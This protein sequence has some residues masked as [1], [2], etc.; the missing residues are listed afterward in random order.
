MKTVFLILT[1]TLAA[2]AQGLIDADGARWKHVVVGKL[3]DGKKFDIYVKLP[4]SNGCD[5]PELTVKTRGGPESKVRLDC[6][7]RM[8]RAGD[9]EWVKAPNGSIGAGLLKF[10]CK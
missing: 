9:E 3:P 5:F 6:Q 4:F 7:R 8:V 1:F 2:S 10:A